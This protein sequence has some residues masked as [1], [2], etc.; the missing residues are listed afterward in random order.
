[1]SRFKIL[2]S[3]LSCCLA[4]AAL[5][6]EPSAEIPW[7][8]GTTKALKASGESGRPVVVD[9]WAVWCEPCKV[10]EKTTFRDPG[11][12]AAIEGFV[13]L[14]VDA[15]ADTVFVERYDI[16]IFPTTLF[17]DEDGREITRLTGLIEADPMLKSLEAVGEG[18][19]SYIDRIGRKND[20]L[21]LKEVGEFLLEVGNPGGAVPLLRKA[22]KQSK[23]KE[24]AELEEIELLLAEALEA[25]GKSGAAA[26]IRERLGR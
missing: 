1:M 4:F 6:D 13:P 25:S 26:K 14:K 21:A 7:I 22:L 3:A 16:E 23:G 19:G 12:L 8:T 9:L 20:P 11:V 18:Y 17:L 5:A 15:D 2:V 24:P 10:M